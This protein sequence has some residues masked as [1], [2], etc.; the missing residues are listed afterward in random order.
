MIVLLQTPRPVAKRRPI[1]GEFFPRATHP[2]A[3][4]HRSTTMRLNRPPSTAMTHPSLGAQPPCSPHILKQHILHPTLS[5]TRFC[6]GLRHC[7]LQD[8]YLGVSRRN[9]SWTMLL[10]SVAPIQEM[11]T[12][13]VPHPRPL[14]TL[15]RPHLEHLRLHASDA[16]GVLFRSHTKDSS[17]G[18]WISARWLHMCQY[19]G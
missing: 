15:H 8:T 10:G 16:R 19:R 12:H 18:R 5:Q 13:L 17:L 1:A 11:T 9:R 2:T 6:R 4:P 14:C 7:W 3:D